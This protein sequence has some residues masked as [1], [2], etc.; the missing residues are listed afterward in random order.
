MKSLYSDGF[1]DDIAR[2]RLHKRECQTKFKNDGYRLID[3][4]KK[5]MCLSVKS[6]HQR[7]KL[8]LK[9]TEK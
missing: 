7:K 5:S 8:V 1:G 3:T 2:E 6:P 4:L 9:Y